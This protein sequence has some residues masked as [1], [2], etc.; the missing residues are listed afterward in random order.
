[1]Q[2]PLTNLGGLYEKGDGV[3][4]DYHQARQ[5]YE[6]G[7]M[8]GSGDAM[9]SLG[10]LYDQGHGVA[11]DY[12]QAR[13]WYEKGAAAGSG[14]AMAS[15][16]YL[17]VQ[18]HGVAQ[19]YQQA[20]QWYEKA[21]AAGSGDAMGNGRRSVRAGPRGSAGLPARAAVVRKGGGGREWGRHGQCR[22]SVRSRAT[23]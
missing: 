8:A 22:R 18:G 17:Y 21:A 23:V 16:G 2:W 10:Y 14:G 11:Q 15:L 7:A 9:A 1:M 20:R 19:D 5:W 3:A 13:Q 12:Q 4:Q 6:M